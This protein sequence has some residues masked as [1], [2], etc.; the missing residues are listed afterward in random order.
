MP[1][2]SLSF[3]MSELSGNPTSVIRHQSF[4]RSWSMVNSILSAL[5]SSFINMFH[6]NTVDAY[7]DWYVA[8]T[9][10]APIKK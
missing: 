7:R 2:F 10:T 6:A 9:T 3:D 1:C 4:R 5:I 8:N